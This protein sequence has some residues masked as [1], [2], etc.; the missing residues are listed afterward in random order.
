MDYTNHGTR[1]RSE[2]RPVEVLRQSD[3]RLLEKQIYGETD[4]EDLRAA[5]NLVNHSTP[6]PEGFNQLGPT[7]KGRY[8]GSKFQQILQSALDPMGPQR[9]GTNAGT[10]CKTSQS[11]SAD[12][13]QLE[14]QTITQHSKRWKRLH[15]RSELASRSTS[16]K[17]RRRAA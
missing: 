3:I 17:T 1:C 7:A 13:R 12:D 11:H 15:R 4:A 2:R 16:H 9:C 14:T 10:T 6:R 8:S 5:V